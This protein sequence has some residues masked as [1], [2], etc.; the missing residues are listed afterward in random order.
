MTFPIRVA[1]WASM[2]MFVVGMAGP[3]RA[4]DSKPVDQKAVVDQIKAHN[5]AATA[6]YGTHNLTKMRAEI[7][8]ALTL[9]KDKGIEKHAALAQTYVLLG[10]VEVEDKHRDAGI[11][12]FVKALQ[13]SPAVEVPTAMAKK[14]V[15]AAFAKAEDQDATAATKEAVAEPAKSEAKSESKTEAKAEAK[16]EAKAEAKDKDS[17]DKDKAKE[18]AA[19][20]EKDKQADKEKQASS[21]EKDKLQQEKQGKDKQ[22]SDL[23]ERLA[24]LEKEKAERDK[25]L[26]LIR[27]SEK[28]ERDAREKLDQGKTT[29]EKQL[30]EAK[31]RIAQLEKEKAARDKEL[32][33]TRDDQK[34]E[35][36]AREK[37]EKVWQEA[38]ARE[39]ER[40]SR[41]AKES[42]EREKL[43][44]GPPLPAKIPEPIHCDIP[45][46]VAPGVDLYVHCVA[47]PNVGAKIIS[48]YYRPTG[49][50][51]FNAI[52]M[53]P[54]KKGWFMAMIPGS[55][56][57]GKFLHYYIEARDARQEVAAS[58]GKPTS[59]NV[60]PIRQG[61]AA[62]ASLPS[63]STST[64]S[65]KLRPAS[66]STPV[67]KRGK[68]AK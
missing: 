51:P 3:A 43:A 53:D 7:A 33:M 21:A 62:V 42:S 65:G 40:K 41:E 6:A 64:T 39:K 55:R 59:P 19:Q 47:Q 58:N 38:D 54:S 31:E 30:A 22:I 63:T 4:E 26:V 1:A 56:I 50:V 52:L 18:K 67:K 23:K 48:F 46:E 37:L 35:R 28:K 44:E 25:E 16:S 11:S 5:Q 34:K 61:G 12:A 13:M 29:A 9:A 24:Q 27:D 68:S 10:V 36:D 14:P 49:V 66:S 17:S 45:D 60:M 8:G 15:K 2:L 57:T 32:I 20:A